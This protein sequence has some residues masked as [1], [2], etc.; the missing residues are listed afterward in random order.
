[1]LHAAVLHQ[2]GCALRNIHWT[3]HGRDP[4]GETI[5]HG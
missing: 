4:Y 5:V 1:L 3:R 2:S